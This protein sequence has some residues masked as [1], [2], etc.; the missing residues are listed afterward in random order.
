[1]T[2]RRR[3]DNFRRL[4]EADTETRQIIEGMLGMLHPVPWPGTVHK[5][6]VDDLRALAHRI[7]SRADSGKN[8]TLKPATAQIVVHAL[9]LAAQ[10]PSIAS[11]N[12]YGFTVVR[13]D[14]SGF[15]H[16]MVYAEALDYAIGAYEAAVA[17]LPGARIEV[18]WGQFRPR[19]NF[20]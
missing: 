12:D 13:V 14:A 15:P 20:K 9:E 19:K 2:K 8:V 4:P 17:K 7:R 5:P 10:A 18:R 11:T 3:P 6:K 1:M 16:V